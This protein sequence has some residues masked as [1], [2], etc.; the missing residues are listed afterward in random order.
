V[1]GWHWFGIVAAEE[2]N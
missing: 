2:L 1:I